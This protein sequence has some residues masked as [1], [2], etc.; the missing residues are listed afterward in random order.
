MSFWEELRRRNVVKVGVAYAVVAWLLIQIVD[1]VLPTFAAPDWVARTVTFLIIL[2]FPV[3]LILAWAYELTPEG[4]KKTKQ[5]PLSESITHVSGRKL[6]F[7]IIGLMALAIAYLIVENYMFDDVTAES[8]AIA[9]ADVGAG[10][11]SVTA[12]EREREVLPNSVAVLPFENLSPDPDNAYFAAGMHEEILNQLAKLSNL[13]VISRT[14]ML[15][16]AEQRKPLPEIARELNVQTVMEGSV[17]YAGNRIRVTMQLIDAMT[18]QHVWSETY[19]REFDDVFAIESD[20][21]MNVANALEAEFSDEEQQRI[22][23]APTDSS[24]A[25]AL[26]LQANASLGSGPDVDTIHEL[27]DR[28]IDIDPEFALAYAFQASLY[29]T[30]LINTILGSTQAS[31]ELEPLVRENAGRALELDPES[32]LALT[33]LGDLASFFW[34]WS[35]AKE[36]YDKAFENGGS[37]TSG[38][39]FYFRSWSGE[40]AKALEITERMVAL[41]PLAWPPHFFYGVCLTYAR[42]YDAAA[43]KFRDSIAL[44]PGL[45]I[46]HSWLAMTQIGLDNRAEAA[47]ELRVAEQLLGGNRTVISLVDIAYGY[48][49]I[50]DVENARRLFDEISAI[51]DQG[52]DIGSGGWALTH[53]AVGNVDEALEWLERGVDKAS[54]HE[55]DAGYYSLMNVKMNY[56]ADPVLDRPEF[57]DVRNRLRG[58]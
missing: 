39:P 14:T 17:R 50:G 42:E 28:A 37:S 33:A 54:R 30:D 47:Q 58:D 29:A 32:P 18:D 12:T 49:R 21:A 55:P 36:S 7:A 13:N 6:D 26:L 35:E 20:I 8:A 1:V 46:Q 43:A 44:A 31:A 56:A 34:H 11:G 27:L 57:V 45:S 52:Q 4:V 23:R 5:V 16:Y 38:A 10:S 51:G 41:N 48:G 25:Y 3:A 24:T 9:G 22:E 15:Q 53:L 40:Q 2:G 19:E